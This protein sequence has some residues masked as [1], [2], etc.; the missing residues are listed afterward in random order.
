LRSSVIGLLNGPKEEK[1]MEQRIE[2]QKDKNG[3]FLFRKLE[4]SGD[5]YRPIYKPEEDGEF[6]EYSLPDFIIYIL[7]TFSTVIDFINDKNGE[8]EEDLMNIAII[9]ETFLRDAAHQADKAIDFLEK[10][11]G[12]IK[13]KFQ[14]QKLTSLDISSPVAL[15]FKPSGQLLRG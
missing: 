3:N 2:V 4:K 9:L 13:F 7:G 1:N 8:G 6:Y 12:D 10:A 15:T 14:V 11:L 5:D